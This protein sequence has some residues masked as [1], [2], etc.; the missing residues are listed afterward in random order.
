VLGEWLV[1][2][3]VAAPTE[4]HTSWPAVEQNPELMRLAVCHPTRPAIVLGSTQASD[5]VDAEV[6]QA[7]GIDVVHRRSGGGAVL[8]S[9]DDPVWIDVWLPVGDARWSADVTVAFGWVGAAWAAALG[10]VGLAGTEVQGSGP[11]AC[12]RWSSL[13][14]FGGLG[15]GEVS[16]RGRKVVGLAQ[17]RNRS[18]AWFHTACIRHWN[19]TLLVELLDLPAELRAAA[20]EG[21][22]G[23]V[24]GVA[25]EV[26]A[27]GGSAPSA[28][29]VTAAFVDSLD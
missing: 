15:A 4:L 21:L 20:V 7:A 2:E 19:P 12:T 23:A 29:E 16:V 22:A 13:V 25:D 9:P 28:A 26:T 27:R 11:G 3:R 14:C 24:T 17:R 5:V 1:D 8:V 6:A 18:G 10:R